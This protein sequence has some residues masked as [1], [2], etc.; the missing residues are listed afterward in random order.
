METLNILHFVKVLEQGGI[1]AFIFNNLR[2]ISDNGY[3]VSFHFDF[4][5][6][7]NSDRAH[8]N[9][10]REYKCEKFFFPIH[11]ENRFM[12][13]WSRFQA[14]YAVLKSRRYPVIHFESVFPYNIMDTA[15]VLAAWMAG[16]PVR[17]LHSHNPGPAIPAS[18]LRLL[19]ECLCR[20]IN[21]SLCT[22]Y[23]A[24]SEVA[25]LYGFGYRIVRQN[26]YRTILNGIALERFRYDGQL[27]ASMKEKLGRKNSR[28]IGTVGRLDKVK[29]HRL[30]LDIFHALWK[31]DRNLAL[32]IV[33]DDVPKQ[34]T[35]YQE[36]VGHAE[37]LGIRDSVDFIKG[38][39]DVRPYL[40][41][42]DLFVVTSDLEALC[43]AAIEAQANGLRVVARRESV[44]QDAEMGEFFLWVEKTGGI[45]E[46]CQA[47]SEGLR[48]G[49]VDADL[50]TGNFPRYDIR[51]TAKQLADFYLQAC[52]RRGCD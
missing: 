8:E 7:E 30:L 40:C 12:N 36:L 31:S 45:P 27:R 33:G 43:I 41:C 35:L 13:Y 9:E 1:E 15:P 32:M 26:K 17:I 44:P 47:V 23:A 14:V 34:P 52:Q 4:I 39:T 25:A 18:G 38:V 50:N 51:N 29:K 11:M 48:L 20:R 42:M 19:K 3:D 10:I 22:D 5:L 49:R 37:K 21:V 16:T 24:P 28:I 46:W 6:A 2:R